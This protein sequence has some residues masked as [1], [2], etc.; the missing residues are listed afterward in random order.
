MSEG[1][2]VVAYDDAWPAIFAEVGVRLRR[3]IGDTAQRIDHIGSTAVIGLDAK[4]IVDIQISVAS[5]EPL[6]AFRAPI[7]RA[8]FIH[9][10]DNPE[11]TKRYFRERPGE[12]RTHIHVRRA[13][14]FSEQFS[15]LFREFLRSHPD[16]AQKYAELKRRLA[17]QY[18]SPE[19][20]SDYVEAKTPFIWHTIH[21]AAEWAQSTG[22]EPPLSD[23]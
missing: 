10:P 5:F 8:G 12:R 16:H 20:R 22:W 15:L 3:E 23:C 14:S 19:Q 2:V 7:E 9:R 11:R 18:S 1:I 21:L 13:G 17:K 4:P 6:D